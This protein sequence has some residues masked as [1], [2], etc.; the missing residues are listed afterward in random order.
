MIRPLV[1]HLL[2]VAGFALTTYGLLEW[3]HIGFSLLGML[4]LDSGRGL[5]PL[6]L[7]ILGMAMIPPAFRELYLHEG[8][9]DR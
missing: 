3:S 6:Y 5:H 2:L 4:C 8:K 7:L 1:I 9:R